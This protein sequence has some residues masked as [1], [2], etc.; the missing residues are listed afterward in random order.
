MRS[1]CLLWCFIWI[2]ISLYSTI[3]VKGNQESGKSTFTFPI[4]IIKED[5]KSYLLYTAAGD[6]QPNLAKEF[7]I[8]YIDQTTGLCVP[9]TPSKVTLNITES[10]QDNPLYDNSYKD[11]TVM[12]IAGE[13][14]PVLLTKNNLNQVFMY[15]NT[16][17]SNISILQSSPIKDAQQTIA[18]SLSLLSTD[19]NGHIIT[20]TTPSS[21]LFG[22][23]GSGIAL[24]IRGFKKENDAQV[25]VFQQLNAVTGNPADP[26]VAFP[27]D[28]NSQFFTVGNNP[29][30][31]ITPTVFWWDDILQRWYIGITGTGNTDPND[32]IRTIAIARLSG[33]QLIIDEL[34]PAS[35]FDGTNNDLLIGTKGSNQNGNVTDIITMHTSKNTAYLIVRGNQNKSSDIQ[36]IK[37]VQSDDQTLQ[38][39]IADKNS[40]LQ[41]IYKTSIGSLA[42]YQK[43][44][45][46]V[47]ATTPAQLPSSTNP[48]T[49]PGDGIVLQGT[50]TSMKA[51]GDTLYV[52]TS[53]SVNAA[54]NGIYQTT[55]IVEPINGNITSW[56]AWEP[57]LL[58]NKNIS[59]AT[60]NRK[61]GTLNSLQ[62]DDQGEVNTIVQTQWIQAKDTNSSV[63]PLN[64]LLQENKTSLLQK[65][66]YFPATTPGLGAGSLSVFL[67]QQKA[68]VSFLTHTTTDGLQQQTTASTFT[69]VQTITDQT[70]NIIFNANTL[71]IN[72]NDLS[73]I[74][75]PT[76]SCIAYASST[77]NAWLAFAGTDGITL[78]ATPQGKGWPLNEGIGDNFSNLPTTYTSFFSKKIKNVKQL[79]CVDGF[80]FILTDTK[81]LRMPLDPNV[82]LNAPVST[83]AD[84]DAAPFANVGAFT[85]IMASGPLVLLGTTNGLWFNS[86]GSNS[87][88][89]DNASDWQQ[90]IL[91]ESGPC[92]QDFTVVSKTGYQGDATSN[93][94]AIVYV[95]SKDVSLQTGRINRLYCNPT[96]NNRVEQDTIQV[97]NDQ[98]LE[99]IPSHLL[100]LGTACSL[101]NNSKSMFFCLKSK[102]HVPI[103]TIS[104]TAPETADGH[105]PYLGLTQWVIP[106][107]L[108]APV[109][110]FNAIAGHG[111]ILIADS[112]QL[113][114][115]Q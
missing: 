76:C 16:F 82:L 36:A 29:L 59:F 18:L 69:D 81:L 5:S 75:I 85:N 54:L 42:V 79:C 24:I 64:D 71:Y 39:K 97:F 34:V 103:A 108:I 14:L 57:V 62:T 95:Y 56:T 27:L 26:A 84:S 47:P 88:T 70:N 110:G 33:H 7:S 30:V 9:L 46:P 49:V 15:E 43:T 114:V 3:I 6:H 112:Q 21:G 65:C 74:G 63:A 86:P 89:L 72:K 53:G 22:D 66:I 113:Y 23:E 31:S 106:L 99:G 104:I 91:P 107:L 10:N 101:A 109:A 96:I 11:L 98:R 2:P 102:Q 67:Y 19:N 37:L 115:N 83:I 41:D 50:I 80:L 4:D 8:S 58:Q 12:H 45:T 92:I 25:R 111:S 77:N 13:S 1:I 38:G 100:D 40:N 87:T 60:V 93:Q 105:N 17:P 73:S 61:T 35:V 90:A 51:I 52:S 94:G 32:G 28:R 55:A 44:L 78:L 48:G 68:I 20:C